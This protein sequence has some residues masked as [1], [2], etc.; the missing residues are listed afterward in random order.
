M[1]SPGPTAAA[2]SLSLADQAEALLAQG[3]IERAVDVARS[4]AIEGR[5]PVKAWLVFARASDARSDDAEAFA[6]YR[7]AMEL[8]ADPGEVERTLATGAG[9]AQAIAERTMER[10]RTATGI[11]LPP[12][13]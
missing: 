8:S 5:D 12:R 4:A 13:G 3:Q 10:V 1:A 7:K 6:A 11:L 2:E 9:K